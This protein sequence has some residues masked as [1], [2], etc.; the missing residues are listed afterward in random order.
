[1]LNQ[2]PNFPAKSVGP[3]FECARAIL[4]KQAYI[5]IV[6]KAFVFLLGDPEAEQAIRKDK[7]GRMEHR[8]ER[9]RA[10]N[11]SPCAPASQ[12]LPQACSTCSCGN[13][14]VDCVSDVKR[15]R[16]LR[17]SAYS[18]RVVPR[19]VLELIVD[20]GGR[21]DVMRREV[22][23]LVHVQQVVIHQPRA[24][25]LVRVQGRLSHSQVRHTELG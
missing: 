17:H 13:G 4:Q 15:L 14:K 18:P 12:T 11:P 9:H 10:R 20:L 23:R 24:V 22:P 2:L 16:L 8:S 3:S 7:R 5:D 6:N 25:V 19:T 1:M 21:V